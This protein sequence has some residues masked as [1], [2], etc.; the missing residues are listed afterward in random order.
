MAAT[1]SVLFTACGGSG[2]PSSSSSGTSNTSAQSN[3]SSAVT[4]QV[5]YNFTGGSDGANPQASPVVDGAG[6]LYGSTYAAGNGFG[7]VFE[8]APNGSG[9]Y[10]ESTLYRFVGGGD[11]ANPVDVTMDSAGKLYGTTT[12]GGAGNG[13]VFDLVPNGS[14]YAE[15]TLYNFGSN[16]DGAN[17][18]AGLI[19]DSAGDLYGT[20]NV[21]GYYGY[22]SVFELTPDSLGGYTESIIYSFTGGSGGQNPRTNLT[23]DNVGDIYG[24]SYYG[25]GNNE[26]I[27]FE[28][29]PN[30]SGFVE[31]T[32]Y[33]FIG[34]ADGANPSSALIMDASGDLFGAAFG[35][36]SGGYG[37]VFELTANGNGGYTESTVYTFSGGSDGANPQDLAGMV[38]DTAGDLYGTTVN[39]GSN[40]YGTVFKLT[41]NGSGGYSESVVYSFGG[42]TDGENP[43]GLTMGSAGNLYGMTINGGSSGDGTVFKIL[44]Q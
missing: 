8:L 21:G 33:N 23:M 26:G 37:T 35:G 31:T 30:G 44:L 2:S 29:I 19:M 4:E 39:G 13:T 22:G 11:G 6:D 12:N 7:T 27:V 28:L 42:G 1:S 32:I 25:G 5:L 3:P 38:L 14:A 40:G 10:A 15:S 18:Y 34:G 24:T 9:G 17:P 36:G 43:V 41:P 16:G 20:T